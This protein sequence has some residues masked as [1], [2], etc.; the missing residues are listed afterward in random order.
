VQVAPNKFEKREVKLGLS[1]GIK[2]EVLSGVGP[3]DV[4]KKPR[5][6]APERS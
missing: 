2:A 6:A 4:L 3:S 5:K 1:D